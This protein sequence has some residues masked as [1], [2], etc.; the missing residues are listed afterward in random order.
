MDYDVVIIGAGI[1]GL[2]CGMEISKNGFSVLIIEKHPYF[3]DE[4]SS[5]NSEVIHAGIYYKEN[6]LKAKLCVAGNASIYEHCREYNIPFNNCGKLIVSTDKDQEENL[7]KIFNN[8]NKIGARNL[9]IISGKQAQKMEPSIICESAILSP[10]SGIVDTY[11]LMQSFEAIAKN[12][13]SDVIYNHKLINIDR[14]NNNWISVIEDSGGDQFKIKSKYF[15][16][17]A[18]LDSDKIAELAGIDIIKEKYDL[19]YS[20]GRYFRFKPSLGKFVNRLIYPVPDKNTPSLGIH[21][22]IDL[23]GGVRLGP[24]V[25]FAKENTKDYTISDELKSKFYNAGKQYLK[26][27]KFDDIYADYSSIRPKLQKPGEPQRDF[28]IKEESEKGMPG[29]IN[30]IGIES[31]GIT[32]SIEIGKMVSGFIS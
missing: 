30:L 11:R 23:A 27:I 18:G 12:N 21:I 14:E 20:F 29:F 31:P 25:E 1:I 8:A 19:T 2:A 7:I 16:N 22:T 17:S 10:S 15:I 32:A 6:S 24:D 9:E 5:R 3:G 4:V 13:N 28:I 26:Q